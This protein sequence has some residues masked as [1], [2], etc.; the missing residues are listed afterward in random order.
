MAET[1]GK[2]PLA[3]KRKNRFQTHGGP[4]NK[5]TLDP[6]EEGRVLSSR[7]AIDPKNTKTPPSGS[8]KK[9]N[10]IPRKGRKW[11]VTRKKESDTK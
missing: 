11:K 4:K 7:E 10:S 5:E 6:R 1:E 3:K 8:R 9:Q 2:L